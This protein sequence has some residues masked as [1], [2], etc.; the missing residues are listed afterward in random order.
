MPLQLQYAT[1]ASSLTIYDEAWN[2]HLTSP[3]L[4]NYVANDPSIMDR[5]GGTNNITPLAAACLRGH[6]DVVKVLLAGGANPN[7]LSPAGR[8]PLY[9]VTTQSPVSYRF[10]ILRA[11][12]DAKVNIDMPC[13]RDGNTPLMNA[14]SHIKD[15]RVVREL[16]DRGA[17]VTAKNKKG[18][19]AEALAGKYGMTSSTRLHNTHTIHDEA[20]NGHLAAAALRNYLASDPSIIDRPGGTNNVTPLAAACWRGHLDVVKLLLHEGANPNA[21]SPQNRTPLFYLTNRSPAHNRLGT[22]RALLDAGANVDECYPENDLN[23]PLMNAITVVADKGV[24]HELLKRGASLTT[25]NA[26][27]QTAKMLAVGTKLEADFLKW[28]ERTPSEPETLLVEFIISLLVLILTYKKNEFIRNVFDQ[29][30]TGVTSRL[31]EIDSI[32]DE[33]YSFRPVARSALLTH[34]LV[35]P[36][37]K[38]S[39]LVERALVYYCND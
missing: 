24:V 27:G 5:P 31:D 8:S 36:R 12:I 38:Q 19:T 18:E 1:H 6:L 7:A 32:D 20:W 35:S 17:S 33:K 29:V 14:M 22:V 10:D 25:T 4:K 28:T 21:M 34:D 39:R 3:A 16:V 2:G 23:T 37:A 30:I 11:L 9:F 26:R 13:D 15:K